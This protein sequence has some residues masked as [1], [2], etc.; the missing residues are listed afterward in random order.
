MSGSRGGR[1][2]RRCGPS[3]LWKEDLGHCAQSTVEVIEKIGWCRS[4]EPE[5]KTVTRNGKDLRYS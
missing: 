2:G 5:P 1:G 4:E 3:W